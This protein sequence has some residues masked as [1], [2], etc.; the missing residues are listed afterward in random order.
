MDDNGNINQASMIGLDNG[1]G[2][3]TPL[4]SDWQIEDIGD[5]PAAATQTPTPRT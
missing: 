1:L 3:G 4:P 5:L 2:L